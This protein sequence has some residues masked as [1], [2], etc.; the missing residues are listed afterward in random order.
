[1]GYNIVWLTHVALASEQI[2]RSVNLSQAFVGPNRP[3]FVFQDREY[4]LQ[5]INWGMNWDF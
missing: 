1:M 4:W 5:G 3:A 2:D